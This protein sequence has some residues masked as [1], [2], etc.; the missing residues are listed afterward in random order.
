MFSSP[1]G[2]FKVLVYIHQYT[3]NTLNQVLNHYLNNFIEKL[4]A[5]IQTLNLVI[6]SGSSLQ[7]K[8]ELK[9]RDNIRLILIEL[10]DYKQVLYDQASERIEIDLDDGVLVNYNK[11]GDALAKV[12]GLND[13]K[14]KTKVKSF[15]WIDNKTIK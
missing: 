7:T 14:T 5:R 6:E 13:K 10:K 15:D 3:S 9:E 2:T 11:F 1:K 8:K 4:K 12:I